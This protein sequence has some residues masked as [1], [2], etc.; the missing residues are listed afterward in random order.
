MI[1]VSFQIKRKLVG[2][3][4][5]NID[6]TRNL[7]FVEIQLM[8]KNSLKCSDLHILKKTL[9]SP[10]PPSRVLISSNNKHH[11]YIWLIL[12]SV[13]NNMVESWK[14]QGNWLKCHFRLVL[15]KIDKSGVH[16]NL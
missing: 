15:T 13:I 6:N 5:N 1:D 7:A 12:V 4:G 11:R 9:P 14:T 10:P 2:Y 16:S 3:A 8:N